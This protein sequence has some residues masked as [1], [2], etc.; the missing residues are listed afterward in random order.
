MSSLLEENVARAKTKKKERKEKKTIMH[1]NETPDMA[2]CRGVAAAA[3]VAAEK[4]IS[5][6]N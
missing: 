2:V 4:L 3:T 6:T 5:P 1:L